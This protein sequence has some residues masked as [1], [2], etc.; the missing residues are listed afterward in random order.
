MDVAEDDFD[1]RSTLADIGGNLESI[2]E[3]RG[4]RRKT[5]H[6]RVGGQH[7]LGIL[8]DGRR[9]IRPQAIVQL[10]AMPEFF[11]PGGQLH[12]ADRRH[13]VGQYREIGLPGN[14]VEARGM[15]KRDA[16]GEGSGTRNHSIL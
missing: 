16:Q 5:D 10:N 6:F 12:D 15:N 13:A 11:Q 8:G 2:H 14:E 7:D 9:R 1:L 3:T 4:R